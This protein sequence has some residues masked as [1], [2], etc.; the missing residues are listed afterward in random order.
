M[1]YNKLPADPSAMV[2]GI[3]GLIIVLAGCCCG[4]FAVL[5]IVLGAIGL[6][7][8]NKSIREYRQY[9]DAYSRSSLNNVEMSKVLN[10]ISI[11]IGS[12][13]TMVFIVYYV[14]Y[15][16]LLSHAIKEAYEADNYDDDYY[17]DWE[18]DTIYD[19]S[20]EYEDMEDTII[21]DS[22]DIDEFNNKEISTDS[23]NN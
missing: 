15:G 23:L 1:N 13:V 16:A 5:S 3:I 14:F 11:V 22:I 19:A 4:I 8:A 2:L 10:I 17:Y 21:I 20:N 18:N 7:M 6:F 12:I 9:P